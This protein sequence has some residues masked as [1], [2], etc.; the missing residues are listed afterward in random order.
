MIR[1]VAVILAALQAVAPSF[2]PKQEAAAHVQALADAGDFDPF[3][4][5]EYVDG[6]S[7]WDPE[8]IG[9]FVGAGE[10]VGLGQHRLLNYKPCQEDLGS[11]ACEDVRASLLDWRFNLDE[12]AR[13]FVMWRGYCTEKVGSGA[14][15]WWLQGLT[16]WDAKRKST[17]G[18][19]R[20][21]AL[22]VPEPVTKL[23]KRRAELAARF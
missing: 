2:E 11:Q 12:T 3:T 22:P 21:R 14:A 15:R 17:C 4:L 23:L 16:G 18:H 20:G 7:G 19:R 9:K 1:P 5:L 10:V 13:A 8:A 6:E